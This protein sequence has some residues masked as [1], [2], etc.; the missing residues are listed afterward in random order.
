MAKPPIVVPDKIK[1][2]LMLKLYDDP[3]KLAEKSASGGSVFRAES[4]AVYF[5]SAVTDVI[6]QALIDMD[7]RPHGICDN[8]KEEYGNRQRPITE[9]LQFC[10]MCASNTTKGMVPYGPV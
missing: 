10:V 7:P 8:C 6:K 3:H 5:E 4:I 9:R 2:A 1:A